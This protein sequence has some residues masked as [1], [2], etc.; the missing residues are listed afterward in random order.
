[1]NSQSTHMTASR[2]RTASGFM[3][4]FGASGAPF[5]SANVF[6][7]LRQEITAGGNTKPPSMCKTLHFKSALGHSEVLEMI[8]LKSLRCLLAGTRNPGADESGSTPRTV[9]SRSKGQR[10]SQS[11]YR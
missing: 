5:K 3:Q 1:M 11:G 8:L 2:R 4:W 6:M 9:H 10:P 7:D